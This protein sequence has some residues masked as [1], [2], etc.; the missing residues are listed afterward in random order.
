MGLFPSPLP[1]TP[2]EIKEEIKRDIL[3]GGDGLGLARGRRLGGHF[4]ERPLSTS[5]TILGSTQV[6]GGSC[7]AGKGFS[8]REV[9]TESEPFGCLRTVTQQGKTT[10]G[11]LMQGRV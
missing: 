4:P 2:R 1:P 5:S 10:E 7:L 8:T 11:I 9:F 6:L 3:A